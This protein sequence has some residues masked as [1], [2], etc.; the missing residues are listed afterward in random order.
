MPY[1]KVDVDS[2]ML[3]IALYN[4]KEEV[5]CNYKGMAALAYTFKTK[6]NTLYLYHGASKQ[7]KNGKEVEERPLYY[8]KTRRYLLFFYA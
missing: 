2:E 1:A 8:M 6:P 5:L 3:A 4:Y 7:Y